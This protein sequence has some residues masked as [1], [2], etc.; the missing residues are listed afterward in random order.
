MPYYN[1]FVANKYQ[2]KKL[3]DKYFGKC[4]VWNIK[5]TAEKVYNNWGHSRIE[6]IICLK[7]PVKYNWHEDVGRWIEEGREE[8][9]KAKAKPKTKSKTKPDYV[10]EIKVLMDLFEQDILTKEQFLS[11]LKEKLG[12]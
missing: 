1:K 10:S 3:P 9:E 4:G 11:Q 6:D 12:L 8:E 7:S 2:Y 5:G